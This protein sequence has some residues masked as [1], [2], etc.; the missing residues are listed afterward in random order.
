M[1]IGAIRTVAASYRTECQPDVL[2]LHST[3]AGLTRAGLRRQGTRIVYQPHGWSTFRGRA[4]S[5][6][7]SWVERR[8]A[9]KTDLVLC[10]SEAER[11]EAL[12]LGYDAR[13]ARMVPPIVDLTTYL[14]ARE[15]Y[16]AMR[17]GPIRC[18]V[19]GRVCQQKGQL[20]L[21]NHWRHAVASPTELHLVGPVTPSRRRKLSGVAGVYVH[22][23]QHDV[24]PWLASADVVLM[25][26]LWEGLPLVAVESLA[27]GV[28]VVGFDSANLDDLGF[29]PPHLST[30]PTAA[31]DELV[32]VAA[33]VAQVRRS[34]GY[35]PVPPGTLEKFHPPR[36]AKRITSSCG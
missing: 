25:P 17:S 14:A 15:R 33:R 1:C 18:L 8:L 35:V 3:M 20:A 12:R 26:S 34:G 28:P 31:F 11:Q 4:S 10:L 30:V 9:A 27:A 36:A 13:Q 19:V 16:E 2:H 23:H 21:V 32:T 6:F 24:V 5:P 7:Y 29:A 22:G